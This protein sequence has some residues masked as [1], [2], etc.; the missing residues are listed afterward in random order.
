MAATLRL[1]HPDAKFGQPEIKLGIM[2]GY[3]GT[4][5]LARLVGKGRALDLCLTGRTIDTTQAYQ[6]GLV[7]NVIGTDEDL[8][9]IALNQINAI[10]NLAPIALD[11]IMQ[12]IDQGLDVSL[13]Q[14]LA[15]EANHFALLCTTQD[16]QI[17]VTAFLQKQTPNFCGE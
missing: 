12:T 4:V 16:K 11:H 7:Q 10:T 5:R 13:E 6:W 9:D 14:A 8:L 17:G 3:G 1:A 15:I 2:P